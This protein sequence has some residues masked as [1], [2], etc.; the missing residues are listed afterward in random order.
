MTLHAPRLWKLWR[1]DAAGVGAAVLLTVV[2]YWAGVEPLARRRAEDASGLA[3]LAD[4]E[5]KAGDARSRLRAA[6][7]S[8]AQVRRAIAES[9]LKL[10][11]TDHL[12][13]RVAELNRL[14][15][16]VGLQLDEIKPGAPV[17]ETW[18]TRV[19]VRIAGNGP[20]RA[21]L[22]FLHHLHEA[23][24]DTGLSGAEL[25]GDP[26]GDDTPALFTFDLE[27]YAAPGASADATK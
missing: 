4:A 26:S 17:A 12:N 25:R 27:W 13:T 21:C 11:R 23:F 19:P 7:S 2:F 20:Y 6:E 8:L 15:T 9:P 10:W 16:T 22:L 5:F 3:A 1:I 14:A 18:F 24:P